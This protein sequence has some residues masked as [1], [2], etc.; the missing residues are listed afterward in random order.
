[1]LY[2]GGFYKGS[3]HS[4]GVKYDQLGNKEY[5]GDIVYTR[6]CGNGKCF[7]KNGELEYVGGWK[8]NCFHGNGVLYHTN[9]CKKYEGCFKNGYFHG[10]GFKYDY[11]GNILLKAKWHEDKLVTILMDTDQLKIGWDV[12]EPI[13]GIAYIGQ[14]ENNKPNGFGVAWDKKSCEKIYE[15]QWQN[16]EPNGFGKNFHKGYSDHPFPFF[17]ANFHKQKLNGTGV[18]FGSNGKVMYRGKF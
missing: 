4:Y 8:D 1:M 6:A 11:C 9:G 5:E 13:V 15:G 18:H 17:I 14:V 7:H 3:I 10:S 16:G 12:I 2:S